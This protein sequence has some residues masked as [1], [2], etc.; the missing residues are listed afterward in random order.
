MPIQTTTRRNHPNGSL[1]NWISV[2][3]APV[4]SSAGLL[5][6]VAIGRA[7]RVN[8]LALDRDIIFSSGLTLCVLA[9]L[10]VSVLMM[11]RGVEAM[12]TETSR[13]FA[14]VEAPITV[15]VASLAVVVANSWRIV[16]DIFPRNGV[17]RTDR[18]P[19]VIA[20]VVN[21]WAFHA[22][23]AAISICLLLVFVFKHSARRRPVRNKAG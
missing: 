18:L 12:V 7:I 21:Q 3:A 20:M 19:V 14:A 8:I 1:I 13:L 16:G 6:W 23:T 4:V 9:A 17:D 10:G 2:V 5:L 11:L 22:A 15:T